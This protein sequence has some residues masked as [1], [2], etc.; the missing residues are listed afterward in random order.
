MDR[1]IA[2]PYGRRLISKEAPSAPWLLGVISTGMRW[3]GAW[4]SPR[5]AVL[6]WAP[7]LRGGT[8]KARPRSCL[9]SD[10]PDGW[11]PPLQLLSNPITGD[12][13]SFP[14]LP[15]I[16]FDDSFV[17]QLPG[18]P[19]PPSLPRPWLASV[20]VHDHLKWHWHGPDTRRWSSAV[21]SSVIWVVVV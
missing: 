3:N 6:C 18:S 9:C 20:F 11:V 17:N 21:A 7:S 15:L 5:P 19:P 4:V 1:E 8:R 12:A 16:D 14:P 2:E 13:F 10:E